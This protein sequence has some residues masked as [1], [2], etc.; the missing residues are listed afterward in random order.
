MVVAVIAVR[1][2]QTAADQIV[3]VIVMRHRV[4]PAP[5][6][7][8]VIRHAFG[9]LSMTVGVRGIH[10]DHVLIDVITVWAVKMAVVQIVG[11]VLVADRNVTT[12]VAV[13]VGVAALMNGMRHGPEPTGRCPGPPSR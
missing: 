10:R 7:V 8:R 9:G 6:G 5:C 1:M 2:V 13:N 4:V 3:D 12:A 11:V